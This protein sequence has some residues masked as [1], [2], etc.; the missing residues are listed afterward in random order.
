[1]PMHHTKQLH[2]GIAG[3]QLVVIDDADHALIW[4]KP[5]EWSRAVTAFLG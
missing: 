3:S 5:V 2:D 1:V 4:A